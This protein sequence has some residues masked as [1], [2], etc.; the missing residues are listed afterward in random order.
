MVA[1]EC[2]Y[3]CTIHMYT[4]V[5]MLLLKNSNARHSFHIFESPGLRDVPEQAGSLLPGK[6]QRR[7]GAPVDAMRERLKNL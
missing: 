4:A 7:S 2:M 6:K 5:T 3:F 1:A